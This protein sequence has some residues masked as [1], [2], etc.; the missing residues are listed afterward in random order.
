MAVTLHYIF[1]L[2]VSYQEKEGGKNKLI[3]KQMAQNQS[4][5]LV[6]KQFL[7][8]AIKNVYI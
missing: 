8:D 6:I 1:L 4:D 7:C 5:A 2:S 3:V